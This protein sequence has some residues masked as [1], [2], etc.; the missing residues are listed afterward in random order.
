[1]ATLITFVSVF[2]LVDIFGLTE[3]LIQNWSGWYTFLNYMILRTGY[4]MFFLSPMA[5]LIGGFWMSHTA[6][7]QKEWTVALLSGR[8][9]VYLLKAP[10]IALLFCTLFITY[11][12]LFWMPNI[13]TTLNTLRDFTFEGKEQTPR[14]YRKLHFN[15]IDRRTVRINKFDPDKK[16][17]TGIVVS[18]KK[19]SKISSRVDADR[20]RYIPHK[21]WVLEASRKRSFDKSGTVKGTSAGPRLLPLPPPRILTKILQVD[22]NRS[23]LNAIEYPLLNL[24]QSIQFKTK[25]EMNA[26]PERIYLHWKFGFPLTNLVL[27]IIG[28]TL[29]FRTNFG[30]SAGIG[31]CLLVGFGYWIIFSMSISMGKSSFGTGFFSSFLHLV[32]VYSPAIVTL[33]LTGLLWKDQLKF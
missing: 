26:T 7:R 21:G 2:L 9:P 18:E 3:D 8:H 16:T 14:T 12:N 29:G 11:A 17:L 6:S 1:M 27:G 32:Y 31:I 5:F 22:P 23:D 20:A 33:G 24:L 19:D 4:A 10:I 28:L 30:Q 25:R 13:T 15:L